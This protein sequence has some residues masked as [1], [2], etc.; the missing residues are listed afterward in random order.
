MFTDITAAAFSLLTL[1]TDKS[2][3]NSYNNIQVYIYI[4]IYIY[5]YHMTWRIIEYDHSLYC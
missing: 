4:Y 1:F 5:I 3:D 2:T